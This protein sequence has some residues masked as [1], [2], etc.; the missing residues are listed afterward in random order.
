[1]DILFASNNPHKLEEAQ[2]ILGPSFRVFSP[3]S[4]GYPGDLPETC[5]TLRGNSIQ[6]ACAVWN[7]FQADCFADDTGL[8]IDALGGAPGVHTARYAGED[9]DPAANR[10]RVLQE[11]EGLP[12][13]QRT[14]RFRCIVALIENGELTV[15][16]G[17]CEGHI[18]LQESEGVQG[19]GYD[20]IF[21]PIGLDVTLAEISI[22]EKNA[23]SHR[24]KAM[25]LLQCH[26]LQNR[27]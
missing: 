7:L 3:A 20:S 14:A 17:T 22:E 27:G 21:V 15:F 10:R 16:E 23:L 2:A 26:L 12:F 9:K 4:F 19:F 25:R 6:K 18:A 1:M 5:D 13:E 11:L 8:E 24:G